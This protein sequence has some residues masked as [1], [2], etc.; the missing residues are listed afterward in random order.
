MDIVLR[1]DSPSSP[2]PFKNHPFLGCE[3][4]QNGEGTAGSPAR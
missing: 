3:P 1:I 4:E 2:V